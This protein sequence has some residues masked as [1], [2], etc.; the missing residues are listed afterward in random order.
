MQGEG[1]SATGWDI[2]GS[3]WLQSVGAKSVRSF[4]LFRQWAAANCAMLPSANAGGQY[5]TL[6]C[7]LLLFW[8]AANCAMLPSGNA[9][10][11]VFWSPC[12]W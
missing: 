3:V 1:H 5:S 8:A 9:G 2:D 10:G 11:L 12:K 4:F 6:N 7:K